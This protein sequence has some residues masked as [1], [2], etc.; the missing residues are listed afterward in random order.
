MGEKSD[1]F[2]T[3]LPFLFNGV[4]SGVARNELVQ[5]CVL[6][7]RES[8]NNKKK[9]LEDSAKGK[10]NVKK[11]KPGVEGGG[12]RQNER[13]KEEA[14]KSAQAKKSAETTTARLPKPR[15]YKT[16]WK[17]SDLNLFEETEK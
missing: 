2:I 10:R 8:P 1:N 6:F 5:N 3:T 14:N 17:A 13:R 12:R 9:T 11:S 16:M 7:C 4:A 15:G